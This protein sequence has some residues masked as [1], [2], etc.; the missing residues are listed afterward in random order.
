M[1][2]FEYGLGDQLFWNFFFAEQELH[3]FIAEH[4]DCFKHFLTHLLGFLSQFGRNFFHAYFLTFF[5][6]VVEGF[7]GGQ[8]ND[9][10]ESL[11]GTD[12]DL[13]HDGFSAKLVSHLFDNAFW[14]RTGAVHLVDERK[15]WNFVAFH[16]TVNSQGLSLNSAD[17]TQ[18]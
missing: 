4:G 15:A 17:G 7:H 5:A 10:F 18:N 8:V 2:T 1:N 11:A 9:A 12:R 6:V 14:I 3:H 13:H 16:L